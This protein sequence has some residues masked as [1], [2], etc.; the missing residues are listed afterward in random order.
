MKDET[1]EFIVPIRMTF[2]EK[3]KIKKRA[4]KTNK[5]F[6]A[7]IR[8]SALGCEI[9]EKPD[10]RF[11]E[12]TMNQMRKFMRTL[13]QLESLLYHEKFIDERILKKEIEEWK[14]FR[15]AIRERYL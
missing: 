10:D 3:D 4:E 13:R 15:S 2:T 8:D 6:S 9:K 12:V 1:R 7:F 14:N 11:Y 5:S